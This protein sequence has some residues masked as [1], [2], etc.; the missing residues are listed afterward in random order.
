MEIKSKF[1]DLQANALFHICTKYHVLLFQT[2]LG[3][4][5]NIGTR[6]Q[7]WFTVIDTYL[8]LKPRFITLTQLRLYSR[9]T[10]RVLSS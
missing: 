3:R 9:D 10:L 4:K 5:N 1:E 7:H 8:I 2:N 6:K